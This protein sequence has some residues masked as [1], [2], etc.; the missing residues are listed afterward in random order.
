MAAQACEQDYPTEP[1]TRVWGSIVFAGNCLRGRDPIRDSTSVRAET[2]PTER[3]VKVTRTRSGTPLCAFN[4]YL[5]FS[6]TASVFSTTIPWRTKTSSP[7]PKKPFSASMGVLT[8][9]SA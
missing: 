2:L 5:A 1:S 4:G 3:H 7:I 8:I 9:G 6:R